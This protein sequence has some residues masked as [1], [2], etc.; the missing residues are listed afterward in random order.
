ML[1]KGR[2]V[3]HVRLKLSCYINLC[4]YSSCKILFFII[5]VCK[6]LFGKV[7][8][9]GLKCAKTLVHTKAKKFF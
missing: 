5:K 3:S 1:C 2:A 4:G 9:F 7:S 6:L 8:F